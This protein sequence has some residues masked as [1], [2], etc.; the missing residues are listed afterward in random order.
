MAVLLKLYLR[1]PKFPAHDTSLD[2][3]REY[4][5]LSLLTLVKGSLR[6]LSLG[7]GWLGNF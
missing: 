4:N 5:S 1:V 3:K 2:L 6:L 7:E